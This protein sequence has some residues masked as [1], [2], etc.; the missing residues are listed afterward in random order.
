MIWTLAKAS[1]ANKKGAFSAR[2]GMLQA[3]SFASFGPSAI[4]VFTPVVSTVSLT[5]WDALAS[6]AKLAAARQ[7]YAV[8]D[9]PGALK[10]LQPLA[11][12][13][14]LRGA[15]LEDARKLLGICQFLLGN[16]PQAEAIFQAVLRANPKAQL[17]K[18][19]VI[20]PSISELFERVR[21]TSAGGAPAPRAPAAPPPRR[22]SAAGAPASSGK[23]FTG[24]FVKTNAENATVFS[25]GIFVGTSNQD[26]SLDPGDHKLTISAS[27]FE[28]VTRTFTI[29]RGE[30]L[31]VTIN[32]V[33]A[34][35]RERR[36]AL[37]AAA[38]KARADKLAKAKRDA[39]AAERKKS[40][41]DEGDLDYTSPLPP[42]AKKNQAKQSLA[43]EFFQDGNKARTPPPP[44]PMQQGYAS[45]GSPQQAYPPQ[46]GYNA[47]GAPQQ[48]Y[49]APPVAS[50]KK[51]LFLALMPF[52]IGQFQ[53]GDTGLGLVVLA[54][55]GIGIG[56]YI[57]KEMELKTYDE[58]KPPL[59]SEVLESQRSTTECLNDDE[60]KAYVSSNFTNYQYGFIG[61]FAVAWVGGAIEAM[62]SIDDPPAGAV[63]PATP[64][65]PRPYYG[66][67]SPWENNKKAN[68]ISQWRLQPVADPLSGS[69]GLNLKWNF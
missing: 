53:N 41:N 49:A 36:T 32:M 47:Y 51:S 27:G 6:P 30:R 33:K 8:G 31:S 52:G 55:Q 42:G 7:Q 21:H 25:S 34:G 44:Q 63:P 59:C 28:D 19:D 29:R 18:K 22:E 11:N 24:V 16:K 64:M 1:G 65:A 23:S 45:P 9:I 58:T 60:Y 12:G 17:N 38:A 61:L 2:L 35:E 67:H 56:G 15:Q 14:G 5:P 26:I 46:Q 20:D 68:T 3:L 40:D 62:M 66:L 69:M 48:G 54:A 57:W 50:R 4:W 37:A 43:D 39:E 10:T 13:S